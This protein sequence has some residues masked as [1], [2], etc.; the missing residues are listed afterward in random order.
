MFYILA[1]VFAQTPPRP[2][3]LEIRFRLK[4]NYWISPVPTGK[5]H[6]EVVGNSLKDAIVQR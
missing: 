2:P 6:D 3:W 4:Q 5:K 1:I